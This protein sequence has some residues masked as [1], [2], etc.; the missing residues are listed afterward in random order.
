MNRDDLLDQ[1][2]ED[3]LAYAMHGVFPEREIAATIKPDELDERFE[4]YELLLDLHFIL[5]KDVV[6]FVSELPKHMR[7]IRTETENVSRRT[8]GA[9]DGRIDWSAT[10][11]RRHAEY[12]NDTSLFI[13]ENRSEDYDIA[14]NVV[15]KRLLSIVYRTVNDA[16]TYLSGDYEWVQETWRGN[17][18]LI[19][20]LVDLFERN[21]HVRRIREPEIYEPTERMLTQAEHS[22][23]E[24]YR[25]A[26]NLLRKRQRLFDGDEELLKQLL[27]ETAVTPDDD[28]TL[29]E[30]FVLFRFIATID[31]MRDGSFRLQTIGTDRQEVAH[32]QGDKE[33]A[34]YHDNSARDRDLSFRVE[35]DPDS[36][37][38]SRTDKVHLAAQEIANEYF[39]DRDFQNHTGRPDII[40]LEIKSDD[41]SHE[42]LITEVKN[43]TRTKTVR[44]GIKETLE[45]VA[46]LRMDDEFVFEED[47]DGVFGKG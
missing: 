5:Q 14:E 3:I 44:Q 36:E 29:F 35:A 38:L 4:E 32:F 22:R 47:S 23:Q 9:V 13:C 10:I 21:V 18:D 7:S 39:T 46:F 34:I 19:D 28:D 8:R 37:S 42:Y 15:L 31:D 33:I 20:D 11:K 17:D 12:P 25:T 30:L 43:S 40:V 27:D 26:A 24:V 1:L 6:D 16:D 45:Y 2:T 41:G